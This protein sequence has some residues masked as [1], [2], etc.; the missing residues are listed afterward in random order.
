M[1]VEAIGMI[2]V[3][4]KIWQAQLLMTLDYDY[5]NVPI[6]LAKAK[7]LS[8]S[9]Q[10]ARPCYLVLFS[11][12]DLEIVNVVRVFHDIITLERGQKGTNP[13]IWPPGSFI[14]AKIT[15]KMLKD[16]HLDKS[17]LL[18]NN[19]NAIETPDGDIITLNPQGA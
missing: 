18:N 2:E 16:L 9:L 15:A 6:D 8:I 5:A 4:S 10:K 11:D 19:A 17:L 7:M 12:L 13:N 14:S 1:S 3:N